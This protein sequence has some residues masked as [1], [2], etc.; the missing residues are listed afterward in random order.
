MARK[1]GFKGANASTAVVEADGLGWLDTGKGYTIALDGDRL[2]C[3]NKAGK[4]LTSVPRDVREGEVAEH[5][6]AVREWLED[7]ERECRQTVEGWMLRS[8][9][10]PRAA[11]QAVWPDVAWRAPLENAIVAPPG[12]GDAAGFFRG[13]DPKRGVGVV[14]LD[15][16][17]VWLDSTELA[18]PHPILVPELDDLRALATELNLKQELSQLFRE[19]HRKAPDA[20][21]ARTNVTDY[22]GGEFKQLVHALGKC[23]SLGF[24]VQGGFAACRVWEGG[25]TIEARHWIHGDGPDEP[26]VTGELF[27]VDDRERTL[28][29]GELGPVAYSEGV[30]MA[31]AIHAARV[32]DKTEEA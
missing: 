29:L 6:L 11:L 15:G 8:L 2:V 32:I 23:R 22:A 27:W 19:T 12:G 18:I 1:T 28:K 21:A 13:V 26:A 30:R 25:R 16:E 31:S 20:D 5:L 17:T 4:R 10:V 24:R 3:R 7:H 9:P 14:N